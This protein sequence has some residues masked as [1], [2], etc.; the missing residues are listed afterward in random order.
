MWHPHWAPWNNIGFSWFRSSQC[1]VGSDR[2]VKGCVPNIAHWA[3]GTIL[4]SKGLRFKWQEAVSDIFSAST[5]SDHS[6][7]REKWDL[8]KDN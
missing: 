3:L 2:E 7:T 4:D 5:Q 1:H 8:P 6:P